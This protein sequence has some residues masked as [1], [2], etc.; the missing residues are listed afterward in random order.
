MSHLDQHNLKVLLN[1]QHAFRRLHSCETQLTT[2]INDWG[3]ILDKKGQLFSNGIGGKILEWI[4]AFL[5]KRVI[6]NSVKSDW[7]PVVSA[8]QR[9]PFSDHFY[10]P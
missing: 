3:E 2:A 8:I 9:T 6:V 7:A 5:Q 1:K 4:S 10:S